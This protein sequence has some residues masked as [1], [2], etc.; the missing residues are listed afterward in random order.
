MS[1]TQLTFEEFEDKD[2]IVLTGIAPDTEAMTNSY[3]GFFDNTMASS[4]LSDTVTISAT[5]VDYADS[6]STDVIGDTITIGSSAGYDL[7][8]T[9]SMSEH[10]ELQDRVERLERALLEE[11]EIRK[12][13]PAVQNAYDEYRMLHSLAK[14]H[15]QND[16]TD[17]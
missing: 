15:S 14:V 3:S 10:R 5:G 6:I 1:S 2:I 12:K 8:T 16:L 7:F 4:T 13:H 9:V 11:E 17:Q